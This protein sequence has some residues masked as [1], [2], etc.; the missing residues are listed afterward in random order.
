MKILKPADGTYPAYMQNYVRLVPEDG[1]LMVHLHETQNAFEKYILAL[2]E[3]KHT[4]SYAEGKWTIKEVLVHLTDAER[5]FIYRALRYARKDETPLP[6][7]DENTYVPAS[8]ANE[9]SITNILSESKAVRAASIA[10][11][12]TLNENDLSCGGVNTSGTSTTVL[13]I[14]N[15]VLGHQ[16]HHWNVIK[17]RY[18]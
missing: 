18:V 14:V 1:E 5:I 4:Y 3:S 12:E 6:G 16:L 9:R 17:E 11:I 7:F 8:H 10:F 13:A 2:P 15:I